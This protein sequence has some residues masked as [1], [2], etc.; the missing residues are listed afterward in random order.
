[1]LAV[2]ERFLWAFENVITRDICVL[3]VLKSIERL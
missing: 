1:M 3:G 2:F